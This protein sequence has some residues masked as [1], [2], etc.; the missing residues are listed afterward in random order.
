MLN[1]ATLAMFDTADERFQLLPY[2]TGDSVEGA[3]KAARLALADGVSFLLGPLFANSVRSAAQVS[4]ANRVRVVAFSSDR[5]IAGNGV[6]LMG[7]AP[8][9]EVE[10]IVRF[11]AAQG[12]TRFA[13]LAP[14]DA[15]G[16]AVESA[17]RRA[18]Q[19][20]RT[21]VSA[22][23]FY[24]PAVQDFRPWIG[25]LT[26]APEPQPQPP[27]DAAT[28]SATLEGTPPV[29]TA[30]QTETPV[31]E[32]PFDALVIADGGQ[33][34]RTISNQI[35]THG[36][37]PDR[38][39]VLGTG[40]WDEPGLGSEPG[41]VGSW[42]P[43]PKP[44]FRADFERRYRNVFGTKPPRL[45]TIAYDAA[46][47]AALLAREH[48]TAAAFVDANITNPR[49]FLGRDGIFRFR[50]DGTIDRRLAILRVDQRDTYVISEPDLSF[51]GS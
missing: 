40:A 51:A 28:A 24:D 11:A 14:D 29:P 4:A 34:L 46:A 33:R 49:G 44:S 36:I 42:Y 3:E 35:T 21:D 2:D 32:L 13:L 5:R 6:Y 50:P 27:N 20:N 30:P 18:T 47:L 25:K 41:L 16:K 19:D 7:F 23:E 48:G 9:D 15:Y 17:L 10:R 37:T 8:E 12:R 39:Q 45:A 22:V 43:A 38:V 1:A 31:L 26:P